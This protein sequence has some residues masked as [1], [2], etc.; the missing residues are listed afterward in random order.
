M[1]APARETDLYPPIR[2]FLEAQGYTVHAEVRHADLT[3]ARGD[4]VIVIELKLR[5]GV[6]LLVQAIDRQKAVDSVYVAVPGPVRLDRG[7]PWRGRLAL[8]KRLELGLIVVTWD[9][10]GRPRVEIPTH[11]TPFARRRLT[12]RRFALLEELAGRTTNGNVGGSTRRKI[13]TAYRERAVFLAWRLDREGPLS[14]RALRA[15]GADEKTAS[16]LYDNHYRWFKR[17]ARGVYELTDL[18]RRELADHPEWTAGLAESPS[19]SS[20]SGSA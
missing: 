18:G 4:E 3:A 15:L 6:D 14:T 13:L 16:I 5:F 20:S 7:S 2:D 8:L 12:K 1:P 17:V 19:A 11:P 10:K 9:R